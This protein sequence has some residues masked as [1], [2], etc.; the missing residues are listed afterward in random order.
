MGNFM[1][2]PVLF[3]CWKHHQGFIMC[4]IGKMEDSDDLSDLKNHL[5]KIGDST[6]DLYVGK[7]NLEHI[8]AATLSFL[9]QNK[10]KHEKAY[11]EW[12]KESPDEYKTSPFP[13]GSVWV[14]KIGLEK[15]RYVHIH[16]GRRVPH[17]IRTKA[18]VLKTA[19]AVNAKSVID[20]SNP[21]DIESINQVR[22]DMINLD[23]IK[24]VTMNQELGRVIY[25]FAMKL[26][27]L[28]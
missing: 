23:P 21:L 6:T 16:P 17:T 19:I 13:D 18:N 25:D 15:G 14:F 2:E 8:A 22:K 20:G 7:L 12:I 1:P 4:E 10:I 9:D 28:T 5:K 24:F 3:N 26:G 11:L 27:T